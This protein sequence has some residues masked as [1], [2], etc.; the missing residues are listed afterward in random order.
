MNMTAKEIAEIIKGEIIGDENIKA[1]NFA[2]IEEA[3]NGD[4]CFIAHSKYM[5][6]I[7]KTL[8]SIVIVDKEFTSK[9][10]MNP[11][12][13]KVE[14]P[15][16]SFAQLLKIKKTKSLNKKG[17]S[18]NTQIS[19]STKIGK[20]VFID[21]F[22]SISEKTIIKDN[23]K[24]HSHCFIGENV[25]IGKN[26]IIFPGV[27]IYHNCIIGPNNI[28]HAGTVIGADGFGFIANNKEYNKI[29]Q[30]GNVITEDNVEIGANCTIDRATMGSTIIRKGVKLDNLIQI[31][32]NAEIG[33]NTVIAAHVAIAG[34]TKIGK[35]CMIGGN[36]SIAGHLN[37]GDNV[38]VAGQSG[39]GSNIKD[40]QTV[41]GPFAFNLKDYQ[42]SYVLFKKLPEIYQ[43]LI[44]M[45]KGKN[46]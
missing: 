37:I 23:V 14:D 31:A 28:I 10:E 9:K 35:N 39:I 36:S 15:Y 3:K 4:I 8:A 2:K 5:H 46:N 34:S 26:T 40:N 12:L 11:T 27:K 24:I 43:K 18:E 13:I 42:R 7:K 44:N 20:D 38:K 25:S 6:Y 45:E 21:A 17:I 33:E 22:S 29:E 32:H 19:K 16:S 1:T 30:I 41:Q